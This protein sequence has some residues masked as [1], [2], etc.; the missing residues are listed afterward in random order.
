ML[1]RVIAKH[2]WLLCAA[3]A[4]CATVDVGA[5]REMKP[6]PPEINARLHEAYLQLAEAR[7]AGDDRLAASFFADK[8]RAAARGDPAGPERLADWDLPADAADDFV[9]GRARLVVALAEARRSTAPD[10]AARAQAMFD[11]WLEA[12]ERNRAP[13]RAATCRDAFRAALGALEEAVREN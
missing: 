2:S 5:V 3:L 12:R 1:P 4:A 8:A 10:I 6:P 13:P 9:V 11:C 7:L